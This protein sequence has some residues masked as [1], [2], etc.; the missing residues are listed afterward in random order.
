M[1]GGGGGEWGVR[2][3]SYSETL[4]TGGRNG[5]NDWY[6][7]GTGI[8]GWGSGGYLEVLGEG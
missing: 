5:M 8:P 2:D 7:R 4:E 1:V 3:L 6:W